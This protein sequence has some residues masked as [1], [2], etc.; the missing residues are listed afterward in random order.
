MAVNFHHG[1][2][3]IERREGAGI[4]NLG[5]G[6]R[7][8]AKYGMWLGGAAMAAG[9]AAFGAAMLEAKET[10][11]Y[12]Q[13]ELQMRAVTKSSEEAAAAMEWVK[14]AQMP[15][16]G[17][18]DLARSYIQLKTIG[19]DPTK[20][21]LKLLSDMAVGTNNSLDQA[22]R[23]YSD[24]LTGNMSGLKAFGIQVQKNGKYIEYMFAD[25]DGKMKYYKARD[26]NVVAQAKAIEKIMAM[27]F[28]GAGEEFA[29]SWDGMMWKISD[30]WSRVTM[31]I[32]NAGV[33]DFLSEKLDKIVALIDGWAADGSLE[34]WC[35]Q[36][37]DALIQAMTIGWAVAQKLWAAGE[38]IFSL[39]DAIAP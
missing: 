17:I 2:E 12:Q 11:E 7:G 36:V 38:K 10:R 37:S 1:P 28:G 6:A 35:K 9:G 34:R 23:S 22:V 8:A 32:M 4:G 31:A 39:L 13:L 27:R 21:A 24:A 16:H 14:K 15:P 18:G 3:V 33:F 29:K 30:T 19:I 5:R 26:N 20:G 25:K